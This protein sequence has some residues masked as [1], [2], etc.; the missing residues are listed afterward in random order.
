MSVVVHLGDPEEDAEWVV[1]LAAL[2]PGREVR[3]WDDPG[4]REAVRHAVVWCPP[5]GGLARFPTLEAIVSVGAGVDHVLRDRL[6]PRGVPI[7]RTTGPD[8]VQ[9]MR[10]FVL[11]QVLAHHRGLWAMDRAQHEGRWTPR[12]PPPA[13]RVTVGVMGLGTLGRGAAEALLAA[14]FRVAGW[15][16][17]GRPVP[18]V[19]VFAGPP[20]LPGF[21]SR[22]A[23]LVC[24]LP[25]TPATRGILDARLFDGLPRGAVLIAL[26]R[27]EHLV[28][29]DLLAALEDGR[30]WAASLD[31]FR[32]EPLP[33]GH[34]FW[35]HPRVHV[36]PHVAAMIDADVGAALVAANLER[37]ERGEPPPDLANPQRG[38]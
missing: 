32:E 4:P 22:A 21:L 38:Y 11:L 8:L 18:G 20:G 6:L 7:L 1:R 28:E 19:E 17:S 34:P 33:P 37:L 31:V 2:L 15:S 12:V 35:D 9:R 36:S 13:N 23:I 30:L 24:L 26:G 25:L 14:G 5:E 10:E 27:G 16:A 3:P 29:A